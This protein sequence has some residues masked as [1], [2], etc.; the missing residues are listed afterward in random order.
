MPIDLTNVDNWRKM[1]ADEFVEIGK[2]DIERGYPQVHIIEV[3]GRGF[4]IL[5]KSGVYVGSDEKH[6][7]E[8]LVDVRTVLKTLGIK[9]CVVMGRVTYVDNLI[10][11][12]R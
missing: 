5:S 11:A 1:P 7:I 8:E 2:G 6:I 4:C 10:L 3:P 9:L 12:A